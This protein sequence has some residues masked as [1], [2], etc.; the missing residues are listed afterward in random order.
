MLSFK[1]GNQSVIFNIYAVSDIHNYPVTTTYMVRAEGDIEYEFLDM[2][3]HK[4]F[5][6]IYWEVVYNFIMTLEEP[7][8]ITICS[9]TR[10][11]FEK[12]SK[13]VYEGKNIPKRKEKKKKLTEHMKR[14]GHGFKYVHSTDMQLD[15]TLRINEFKRP[16]LERIR[17]MKYV[18]PSEKQKIKEGEYLFS[19]DPSEDSLIEGEYLFSFDPSQ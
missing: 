3:E 1:E 9:P 14:M 10:L 6:T 7:T 12:Y 15:M 4:H 8:N 18:C 19:F 17:A 2:V 11:N 13:N 16:R 5:D